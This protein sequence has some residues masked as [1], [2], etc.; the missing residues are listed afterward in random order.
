MILALN[1]A[2]VD[3]INK[4]SGN[5]VLGVDKNDKSFTAKASIRE[6]IFSDCWYQVQYPKCKIATFKQGENWFCP[7]DGI[8]AS[9]ITTFKLSAIITDG[10]QSITVV[11]SDNA[12]QYLFGTTSDKLISH[13]DINHRKHL[14]PIASTLQRIPK[15]M[16]LRMTNTSTY[17]NIRF[18]V[19]NIDKS[20]YEEKY[21]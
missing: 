21:P 9:P 15:K 6:Y 17:N 12:T 5:M 18:T 3:A 7:S 19:T 20:P 10:S 16:K 14:P 1:I 13:D 4:D 11:L 2:H 8:L